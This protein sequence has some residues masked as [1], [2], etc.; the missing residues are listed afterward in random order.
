[1]SS[2][3]NVKIYYGKGISLSIKNRT[4]REAMEMVWRSKEFSDHEPLKLK[5][6]STGK[7][8]YMDKDYFISYLDHNRTLEELIEL[9]ECQELYRNIE[10]V[11]IEKQT[12]DAGSL[13]K[14]IQDQIYLIDS[15][16]WVNTKFDQSLFKPI[17]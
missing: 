7:T 13:W 5:F 11:V 14:L 10:D 16:D 15:N 3:V 8:L 6:E 12:I 4:F 2:R 1:M 9:T 17:E